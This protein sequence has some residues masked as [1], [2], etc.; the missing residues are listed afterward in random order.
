MLDRLDKIETKFEEITALLSESQ[1]ISDQKKYINLAKKHSELLPIVEKYKEYKRIV[2]SIEEDEKIIRESDDLE[3]KE[4]AKQEL[5]EL[6]YKKDSTEE[7]LKYLLLPRDPSDAKNVIMEIRAGTGGDEAG[8][9]AADLYRM[10]SKYSEKKDWNIEE[11]SVNPGSA[12]G[13]KEVVFGV[14]GKDVYGTLKY[15]SGVH[16]VQRVPVTEASGRIHT[17]ATTVAV[18]P[19]AKE[20]EVNID[21]K[22]LQFDVFR[23]SG[24]GGQSVNTTDSAVRITHIPTGIVVTCQDEKSQHKNKAKAMKVLRAR[25]LAKIKSEEEQKIASSRKAQVKS[26]DRSEK[27]RTYNYPQSRVT[28]HRIGLTLYKLDKILEG[29]IDEIIEQLKIAERTEKLKTEVPQKEGA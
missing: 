28:D 25:L 6:Q 29:E 1:T 5:E 26:G 12:G 16:R 27:I 13:F 3:L 2:K 15:E 9:F 8:L 19:E 23:S 22:D 18:L 20:V 7:Q 24:P 4:I 14:S 17:S 10:Y 11:I 21:S